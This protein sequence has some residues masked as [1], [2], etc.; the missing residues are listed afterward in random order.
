MGDFA[1]GFSLNVLP[2]EETNGGTRETVNL[3]SCGGPG[4]LSSFALERLLN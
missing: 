1:E 4:A 2:V 3:H